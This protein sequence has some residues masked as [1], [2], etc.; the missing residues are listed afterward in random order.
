MENIHHHNEEKWGEGTTLLNTCL[1]R[2]RLVLPSFEVGRESDVVKEPFN[3]IAEASGEPDVLEEGV[4]SI[5]GDR[6]E[7]LGD[8]EKEDRVLFVVV[9]CFVKE[10]VEVV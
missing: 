1:D 3:S 5:V 10:F 6:V 7:G 2:E 4:N 8:V 9:I